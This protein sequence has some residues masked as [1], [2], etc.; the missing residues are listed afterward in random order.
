MVILLYNKGKL[1]ITSVIHTQYDMVCVLYIILRNV[2]YIIDVNLVT[3]WQ[4]SGN[5]R[6]FLG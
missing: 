5:I 6:G 2:H 1:N 4:R 3:V